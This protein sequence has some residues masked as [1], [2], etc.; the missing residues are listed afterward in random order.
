MPCDQLPEKLIEL[1]YGELT[2][3]DAAAVEA[4]LALC[5]SCRRGRDDLARHVELLQ[6][7]AELPAPGSVESARIFAAA[8]RREA[9][10]SRRWRRVAIAATAAAAVLLAAAA[11]GRRV[12][13]HRTHVV[14]R[15]SERAEQLAPHQADVSD[16]RLKSELAQTHALLARQQQRLDDLER[17]AALVVTELKQDDLRMS[18]TSTALHARLDALQRQTDERWQAVGRGFHDWYLTQLSDTPLMQQTASDL[19][20]GDLP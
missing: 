8:R 19:T 7:A 12:E 6:S 11:A 1:I 14:I 3:E 15:W 9:A 18:R 2:R 20:E 17:F 5:E 10:R 4:H 13:I 16:H